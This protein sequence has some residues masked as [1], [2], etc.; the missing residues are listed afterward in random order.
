MAQRLNHVQ[1]GDVITAEMWN[2]AVDTINEVLEA[3]Q[4]SGIQ[5]AALSPTG[6]TADPLRIGQLL[7]ITGQNFGYWIGQSRVTF[8]GGPSGDINVLRENMLNGSSDTRLLLIVPPIPNIPQA[9]MSMTL[10]VSNGVATDTRTAFVV[11][12]VI[13]LM[14]DMFVTW[15]AIILNPSPNPLQSQ[16]SAV[17]AL[18]LQ[19]GIN[20]PATF[21]L[22][23]DIPNATVEIPP[24]LVSTI[25]FLN[26]NNNIIVGNR[27]EMGITEVRNIFARIPQIPASLADESFT[28]QVSA[29]AGN[30][31]GTFTRSFNVGTTIPPTDPSIQVLQTGWMVL[32]QN[33]DLVTNLDQG[34]LEGSKILLQENLQMIVMFDLTL[35]KGDPYDLMIMPQVGTTLTGWDLQLANTPTPIPGPE[36]GRLVQ[37]SVQ[38]AT[39]ASAKGSIVFRIRR[40][41]ETMEWFQEFEVELLP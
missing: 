21:N 30:V 18:Q 13:P 28:L 32:D 40:Q 3:G 33:G 19:T 14:G 22:S 34:R 8:R 37:I 35:T 27:V 9:G 7:Q 25:E 36:S 20:M 2:L 31:A 41:G 26:E 38:P 4:T 39:G 1:P 6:T 29:T 5:I 15:R 17:F 24:G 10:E 16:Q 11:P 12:V 23:A